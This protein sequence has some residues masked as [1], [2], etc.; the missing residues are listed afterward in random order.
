MDMKIS[1]YGILFM[2]T[3]HSGGQGAKL[4]QLA[5]NI[6]SIWLH[7]NSQLLK[8]LENNSEWLDRTQML[9]VPI[10][11]EFDTKFFYEAKET[12]I[13]AG[14]SLLVSPPR[15]PIQNL[16]RLTSYRLCRNTQRVFQGRLTRSIL[17][18]KKIMSI[19]SNT[20]ISMTKTFKRSLDS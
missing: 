11:S 2:G 14:R 7:T 9:Y 12:P 17:L 19:W 20:P 3:P 10:S 1:T 15:T 4:G 5:V 18:S 16:W 8:H 6:A 13:T